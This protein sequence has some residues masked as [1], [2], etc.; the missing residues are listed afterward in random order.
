MLFDYGFRIV[1]TNFDEHFG[2]NLHM[3]ERVRRNMKF[4]YKF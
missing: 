2:I 1:T 3:V 4:L